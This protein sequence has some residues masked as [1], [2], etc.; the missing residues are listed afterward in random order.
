MVYLNDYGLVSAEINDLF[1]PVSDFTIEI[2]T[3]IQSPKCTLLSYANTHTNGIVLSDTIRIYQDSDILETNIKLKINL[4]VRIVLT[5][6]AEISV[7]TVYQFTTDQL[8]EVKKFVLK[9]PMFASSGRLALG[10]WQ[11]TQTKPDS[12]Q[13]SPFIGFIDEMR[14]W[15]ILLDQFQLT[16]LNRPNVYFMPGISAYWSFNNGHGPHSERSHLIDYT[17]FPKDTKLY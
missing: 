1:N 10:Y 4:W 7:L 13:L 14:V 6:N 9:R 15:R 17:D 8:Y 3:K 5:Y 11:T 2:I 12:S 16:Y